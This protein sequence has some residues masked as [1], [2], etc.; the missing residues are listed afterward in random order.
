MPFP[1]TEWMHRLLVSSKN[2]LSLDTTRAQL[3]M[4]IPED[5]RD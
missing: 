2:T 4:E 3:Q 1:Q 5:D